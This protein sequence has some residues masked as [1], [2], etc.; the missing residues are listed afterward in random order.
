MYVLNTMYDQIKDHK[1][2]AQDPISAAFAKNLL[3]CIEARFTPESTRYYCAL[4]TFDPKT[5]AGDC[6][7]TWW[8]ESVRKQ[9]EGEV[10][11]MVLAW[12]KQYE[13]LITHHG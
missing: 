8:M 6:M 12:G 7:P 3:A 5:T 4:S 9:V 11:E 1:E 2:R 13:E 10:D